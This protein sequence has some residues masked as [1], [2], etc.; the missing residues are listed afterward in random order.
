[1]KVA[2]IP[3]ANRHQW[4]Q[5]NKLPDVVALEQ[6][7][8]LTELIDIRTPTGGWTPALLFYDGGGGLSLISEGHSKLDQFPTPK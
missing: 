6:N 8:F 5:A 4:S 1:M 7:Q 2:H 3:I